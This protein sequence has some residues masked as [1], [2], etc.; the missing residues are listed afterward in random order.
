MPRRPRVD[1]EDLWHH[2]FNRGLARRAVFEVEDDFRYFKS[3]LACAS[4]RKDFE[5]QGY[6]LLPNHFHLLV[7]SRGRLSSG[8]NRVENE[9]VRWFNR[10]R[11]RD[12]SLFR[13]RF[14]S[15]PIR[16]HLYHSVLVRYLDFNAVEAGLAAEP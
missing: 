13:G 1:E 16:S 2:V 14:G 15:K 6:A 8:M 9:Y 11:G 7:R 3:R 10:R 12:G 5:I 4:R